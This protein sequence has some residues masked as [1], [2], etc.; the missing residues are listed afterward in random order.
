MNGWLNVTWK[1]L[2]ATKLI[3]KNTF[4]QSPEKKKVKRNKDI[5]VKSTPEQ[6]LHPSLQICF[7]EQIEIYL[8]GSE[9]D[10]DQSVNDKSEWER[11]SNIRMNPM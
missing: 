6:V 3:K 9:S 11:L 5:S 1:M 4:I 7:D 8:A 10:D 2:M